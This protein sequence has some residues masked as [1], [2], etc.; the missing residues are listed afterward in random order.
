MSVSPDGSLVY[1]TTGHSSAS[2]YL[3]DDLT[4]HVQEYFSSMEK[5]T[6]IAVS[7]SGEYLAFAARMKSLATA[8]SV[9]KPPDRTQLTW[10]TGGTF[11]RGR[12]CWSPD[13]SRIYYVNDKVGFLPDPPPPILNVIRPALP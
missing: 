12:L 11:Q 10:D 3:I 8:V 1:V 4:T 7:P 9:Y 2:S 13:E 6:G 5:G